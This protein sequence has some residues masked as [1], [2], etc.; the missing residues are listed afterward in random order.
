MKLLPQAVSFCLRHEVGKLR[1]GG[2]AP[3]WTKNKSYL[4]GQAEDRQRLWPERL[5]NTYVESFV[6]NAWRVLHFI[7]LD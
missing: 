2:R 4:L 7:L 6:N 3:A 5:P 1:K